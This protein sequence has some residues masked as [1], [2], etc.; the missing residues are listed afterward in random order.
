MDGEVWHPF[1]KG[2]LDHD[3]APLAR[4][5]SRRYFTIKPILLFSQ[6]EPCRFHALVPFM[7][8]VI[9]CTFG[10]LSAVFRILQEVIRLFHNVPLCEGHRGQHA[11]YNERLGDI[12]SM[13]MNVCSVLNVQTLSA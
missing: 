8:C 13:L 10:K 3:T 5:F 9:S 7:R 4:R 1:V 2:L 11:V 12:F 6:R